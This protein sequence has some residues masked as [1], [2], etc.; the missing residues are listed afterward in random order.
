MVVESELEANEIPKDAMLILELI[1]EAL[2]LPPA[3]TA[4][5]LWGPTPTVSHL[6]A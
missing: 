2:E 3:L 6:P 1:P 4:T 5:G